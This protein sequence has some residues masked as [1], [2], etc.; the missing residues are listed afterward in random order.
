MNTPIQGTAADLIKLAMVK[1]D[2]QIR[3]LGLASRLILQV[4]DELIVESP[5]GEAAQA[6][7]ILQQS[8]GTGHDIESALIS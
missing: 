2:T 6:M 7:I 4:H 5:A 8:H 3:Q 1:A